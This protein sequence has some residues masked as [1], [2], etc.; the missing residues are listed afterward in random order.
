MK[1]ASISNLGRAS[2]LMVYGFLVASLT[3][4]L[5]LT[6]WWNL[7]LLVA[8]LVSNFLA[9][10][11]WMTRVRCWVD[12]SSLSF[13]QFFVTMKIPLESID[14]ADVEQ[15]SFGLGAGLRWLGKGEWAMLSGGD[16]LNLTF[17]EKRILA[18]CSCPHRVIELIR[19]AKREDCQ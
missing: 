11:T 2:S 18:S 16:Y 12:S 14:S 17:G 1:L 19:G 4:S 6:F 15:D 9:I 3:A 8:M 7:D 13:R 10:T 5:I